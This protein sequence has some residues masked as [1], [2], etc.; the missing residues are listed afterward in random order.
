MPCAYSTAELVLHRSGV[1]SGEHVLIT[2]ASG[3]V[4]SAAIQL[5]GRRGAKVTAVAGLSK[6]GQLRELGADQVISRDEKIAQKLGKNS[7]DVVLDVRTLYLKDPT[8]FGG[9]FQDDLVFEN[10]VSYIERNEIRPF[11][12]K[13][14]PLDRI[15]PAQ[16]EF[17]SKSIGGKLVLVIP[18][19]RSHSCRI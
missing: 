18:G 3:G 11:V 7:V 14:Y 2:S 5:A 6:A 19:R 16:T 1:K 4:G 8:F 9:T 10:L 17:L 13:T 12:G 15:V